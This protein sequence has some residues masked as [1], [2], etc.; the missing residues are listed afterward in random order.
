MLNAE[1]PIHKFK[2]EVLWRQT[3]SDG[4]VHVELSVTLY[5]ALLP[6]CSL[7]FQGRTLRVENNG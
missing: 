6:T 3:Y 1:N 7:H 2:A 4:D 5:H